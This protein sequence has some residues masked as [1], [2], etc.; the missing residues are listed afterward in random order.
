MIVGGWMLDVGCWML[1][2]G[3]WGRDCEAGSLMFDVSGPEN[4]CDHNTSLEL[5]LRCHP[6]FIEG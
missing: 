3:S 5:G 4:L 2:L 1:E 6:E